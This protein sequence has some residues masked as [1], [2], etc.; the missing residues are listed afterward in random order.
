MFTFST[1]YPY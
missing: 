1:S